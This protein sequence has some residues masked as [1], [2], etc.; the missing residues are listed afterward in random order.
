M[1][2]RH[3]FRDHSFCSKKFKKCGSIR[4]K[5]HFHCSCE[6]L[7]PFSMISMC[8]MENRVEA[9]VLFSRKV[10]RTKDNHFEIRDQS[11]FNRRLSAVPLF[12]LAAKTF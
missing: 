7:K 8:A 6:Q 3:P 5:Q 10:P 11:F 2:E 1:H 4:V 9:T 12:M